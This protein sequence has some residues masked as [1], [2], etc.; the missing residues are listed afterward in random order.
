MSGMGRLVVCLTGLSSY[1]VLQLPLSVKRC[2]HPLPNR[3]SSGKI[4]AMA[5]NRHVL[6][7][8]LYAN[9]NSAKGR[10]VMRL[11]RIGQALPP[12]LRRFY[13]PFYYCVVD[14]VMGISLP[15]QTEVGPGLILRHGQGVVIS[16][17]SRIGAE[18]EIH[19]NVTL[20]E[21]DGAAP[22]LGN[23]VTIGANAVL[24]GGVVIGNGAHVGAGT[25]V[26]SDVPQGAIAIGRKGEIVPAR[27]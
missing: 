3:A 25:V 7:T 20:G 24:L 14:I 1:L 11:F 4:P 13:H 26:L 21:K 2:P 12:G 15:L 10:V 19:Q 27:R 5:S 23:N 22:Q 16:W 9:R 17:K 8:D 6:R 18:C